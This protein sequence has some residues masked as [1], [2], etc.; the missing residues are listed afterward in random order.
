MKS[1]D[2]NGDVLFG[3]HTVPCNTDAARLKKLPKKEALS[4][5]VA[6]SKRME[7]IQLTEVKCYPGRQI[8]ERDVSESRL[9][10]Q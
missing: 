5:A 8:T 4:A 6:L 9:R 10:L 1:G 7:R 3:S 2:R